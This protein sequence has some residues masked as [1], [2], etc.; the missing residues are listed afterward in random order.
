MHDEG[1]NCRPLRI[2]PLEILPICLQY[3]SDDAIPV[4]CSRFSAF[5]DHLWRTSAPHN[6]TPKHQGTTN[7]LHLLDSVS[8]TLILTR[9][10]RN[11]SLA[12]VWLKAPATL[13]CEQNLMSI[14]ASPF[15]VFLGLSVPRCIVSTCQM[16][17]T[18]WTS[19]VKLRIRQ[20]IS[21]SL[22]RNMTSCVCTK[23]II[24]HGSV[25]FRVP[26]S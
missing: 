13:I 3:R 24:Q 11:T 20:P 12:I 14:L 19:G 10:P 7:L 17:T 18:P 9:L 4:S 6:A 26:P 1:E 2:I 21:Y 5:H 8:E 23:S 25:A 16:W 22:S 15:S